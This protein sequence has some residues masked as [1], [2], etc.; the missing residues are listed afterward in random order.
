MSNLLVL[1][2]HTKDNKWQREHEYVGG[3]TRKLIAVHIYSDKGGE[4]RLTQGLQRLF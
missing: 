2:V 1:S 4:I 3:L